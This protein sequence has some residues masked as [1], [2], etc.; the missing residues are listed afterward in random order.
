MV[1]PIFNNDYQIK[2]KFKKKGSLTRMFIWKVNG[3]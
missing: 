1:I 2:V 3:Q